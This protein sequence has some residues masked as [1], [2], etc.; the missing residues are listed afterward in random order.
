MTTPSDAGR[1]GE[2]EAIGRAAATLNGIP[3]WR[4][5]K[6]QDAA[7]VYRYALLAAALAELVTPTDPEATL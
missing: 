1:A 5:I 6:R 2:R 4:P 3:W 7:R